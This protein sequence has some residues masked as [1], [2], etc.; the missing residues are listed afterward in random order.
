[1]N[2]P[3][4]L[5]DDLAYTKSLCDKIDEIIKVTHVGTSIVPNMDPIMMGPEQPI[6]TLVHH[7]AKDT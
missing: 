7:Y 1:M 3:D 5:V 6:A 4:D 2:F